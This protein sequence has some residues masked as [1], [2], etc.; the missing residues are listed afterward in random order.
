MFKK[1]CLEFLNEFKKVK[2]IVKIWSQTYTSMTFLD[3][4]HPYPQ[5]KKMS[6]T[7]KGISKTIT[8][9][10]PPKLIDNI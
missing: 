8:V 9:Q 3:I 7:S 6:Q 2:L 4:R 10:P 1:S 5:M